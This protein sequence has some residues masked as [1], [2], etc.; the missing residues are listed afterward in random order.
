MRHLH[1]IVM[2]FIGLGLAPLLGLACASHQTEVS[3]AGSTDAVTCSPVARI[4]D[5]RDDVRCRTATSPVDTGMWTS[6][7]MAWLS[8][9]RLLAT[10]IIRKQVERVHSGE[11]LL[12]FGT[13]AGDYRG[14]TDDRPYG[15]YSRQVTCPSSNP[16]DSWCGLGVEE[17]GLVRADRAD[18]EVSWSRYMVEIDGYT[19]FLDF[20]PDEPPL[21]FQT[22]L[23]LVV[24][25]MPDLAS[26][27]C[28]AL[29]WQVYALH[30]TCPV[31]AHEA[32]VSSDCERIGLG[33]P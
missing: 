2:R 32:V 33:M 27:A 14:S 12:L 13:S 11:S 10:Q 24:R 6:A 20:G 8:G 18:G 4:V 21:L 5:C 26:D 29:H 25:G 16:E 15:Y 22:K 23:D 3:N 19:Y 17:P 28:Y 9:A 31:T 7:G 1:A 30:Q